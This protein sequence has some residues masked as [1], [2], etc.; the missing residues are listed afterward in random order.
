M[1]AIVRQRYGSPDILELKE[2]DKPAPKNNQVLVKVQAA[3]VNPFDWHLLRGKPFPIRMMGFGFLKPNNQML[4]ADIAGRV[5]A[6]GKD[7]THF[8]VGDEV[9]GS[10][11]GGF[12]EYVCIREDK[13]A[14]KPAVAT[15]ETA[16]AVPVAGLT[17]LQGLRDHGR[18]RP[19]YH[20]LINGASGGVGTFAV[21]IAKA[22]GAQVTGACSTRNLEMVWSIGAD[23]VI[24]YTKEEFWR[25]EKE[26]DLILD[27]AA[28][29]TIN[30]SLGALKPT[31]VYVLVGGPASTASLL[32]SLIL[33][34][35]ISKLKGRKL[36]SFIAKLN[37]ADLVFLKEL[38]ET[39]KVVP[40][41]DRKYSLS[42]TPQAIRYIEEGHARGK[43]V[44]TIG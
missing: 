41:I 20:V 17:A 10:G 9:F 19:G 43:V 1:K 42:E 16:A 11:M 7:I 18:I 13:L 15:F 32:L 37:S 39:G 31:G 3:S 35:L 28:Y 2:V 44:I 14:L 40:V 12:A 29:R 21:Q 24:D 36:V 27:N 25:S 33:N 22:L 5:E 23:N 6:I 4:G 38:L 26:Y 30:K 8:K 34:P